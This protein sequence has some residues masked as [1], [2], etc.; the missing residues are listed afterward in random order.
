MNTVVAIHRLKRRL[1]AAQMVAQITNIERGIGIDD[2]KSR[3]VKKIAALKEKW[4]ED[5]K[6]KE[7]RV[8]KQR[9][10]AKELMDKRDKSYDLYLKA[11]REENHT[12]VARLRAEI[13]TL[14]WAMGV[15]A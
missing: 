15:D 7:V 14:D 8:E 13:A 2:K 12:E 10:S 4:A 1:L 5:R 11:E 3:R 9:R 6:R